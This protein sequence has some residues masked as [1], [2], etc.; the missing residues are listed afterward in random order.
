M[1]IFRIYP[2][3]AVNYDLKELMLLVKYLKRTQG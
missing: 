2:S 3:K 1:K